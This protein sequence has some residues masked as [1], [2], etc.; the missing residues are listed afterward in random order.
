MLLVLAVEPVTRQSS[1]GLAS[2]RDSKGQ[3]ELQDPNMFM[4]KKSSSVDP[5]VA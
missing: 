1:H 4:G 3:Q 5:T 2:E